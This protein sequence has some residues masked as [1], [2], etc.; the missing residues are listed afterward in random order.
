MSRSQAYDVT[1][2]SELHRVLELDVLHE[3]VVQ[4]VHIRDLLQG[5]QHHHKETLHTV[6][7][8]QRGLIITELRKT[9]VFECGDKS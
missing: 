4:P 6:R 7:L 3:D 5:V 9:I 1:G 2:R 8:S